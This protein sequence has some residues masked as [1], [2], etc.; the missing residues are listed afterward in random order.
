[1]L[2]SLQSQLNG[3]KTADANKPWFPDYSFPLT[4]ALEATNKT[5]EETKQAIQED[6]KIVQ[7]KKEREKQRTR[8]PVKIR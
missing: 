3:I 7:E 6:E 5:I 4:D 2:N 1:M 8:G